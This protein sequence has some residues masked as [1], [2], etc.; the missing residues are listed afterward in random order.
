MREAHEAEILLVLNEGLL[1]RDEA[2]RL[3]EDA[4]RQGRGPLELLRERGR[5]S[6]DTLA[7]LRRSVHEPAAPALL[8]PDGDATRPPPAPAPGPAIAPLARLGGSSL[9]SDQAAV[10]PNKPSS[11]V[12]PG[13][14]GFPLPGWERYRPVRF[15][16]QGGMGRVFLAYDERLHREVA[17]KFVRQDEPELT[18]RFLDEARL[19]ARVNHERVCKVYEVGQEQGRTYIAMQYVDGEPLGH[20]GPTLSAEQKALL[21]RDAALGVHEAHRAGL[22]HRDLKPSNIMV[23]RAG[24]GTLK[25][26]VMDFG[27]ARE[28]NQELTA[29]GT[30]LGTPHYMSP[31]QARGEVGRLDRRADV[32]S[33]GATLYFLLTGRPPIPGDNALEVLSHIPTHEPHPPR[34]VDPDIPEDLEAIALKCLEKDRSARYDSARALADDLERFLSGEPVRARTG[35]GYRLRKRLRKHRALVTVF[36]VALVLVS[37]TALWAGLARRDAALR[38]QLA[39]RFTERVER[40]ESLAR[41]SGLSPLHDTRKDRKALRES[42]AALEAE[43]AAGGERALGPGHYA[44]G[45]G[46]LAL[47][48]YERARAALEKAWEH[49]ERE[50]RVAYALAV[51]MGRL[52]QEGLSD[53]RRTNQDRAQR[54]ARRREVE[55]RFRDPALAYLQQSTGAEV[56]SPAYV[57][58][59]L[60]FY[61][62]RYEDALARLEALDESL[63]WFYEGSWLRGDI[64]VDRAYA[65]WS[66]GDQPGRL[67]DLEAARKAYTAAAAIGESVPA[68]HQA[69]ARLE[70]MAL[71]MELYGRGADVLPH[72]TRAQEAV[73]RAL[74]AAP[75]HVPSRV[76]QAQL[77]RRLAEYRLT[78][79]GD[80]EEPLAKALELAQGVLSLAPESAAVLTELG[81]VY[82]QR[83]R[84]RQGRAEDPRED[85]RKAVELFERVEPKDRGYDFLLSLGLVFT[86]WADHEDK[87]GADASSSRSRAIQAYQDA[88]AL[89]ENGMAAWSNLGTAYFARA[90][91]PQA[92][93]TEGDLRKARE[94]LAKARALNPKYVVPYYYA[95]KVAELLAR[96]EI[97]RGE[98]G[99]PEL[100]EAAEHYR[101]GL[102]VNPKFLALLNGM[103]EV[104]AAHA[105]EGWE[106]G[107]DPFPLLGEAVASFEKMLALDS[108]QPAALNNAGEMHAR[109]AGY[110]RERGEDP[111]LATRQSAELFRRAAEVLT[112]SATPLANLALVHNNLSLFELEHG[113]DPSASLTRAAEAAKGALARSPEGAEAWLAH[114][115]AQGLKARWKARQGQARAEDFE[116]AHQSYEKALALGPKEQKS[117]L[118]FGH[119]CRA[120][121]E[122]LRETNQAPGPA[123]KRAEELSGELLS[124]RPGWA[125]A[126]V[127]RATVLASMAETART[128]ERPGLWRQALD[129]LT[130]A[131]A[132]NPHL[133]AVWRPRLAL[134]QRRATDS[135]D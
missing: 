94:A 47:E 110:Q 89:D 104:K 81:S 72:F 113:R 40:I 68:I 108:K 77:Y 119:F 41:Y 43:I 36:A 42:M 103:G 60:A 127:L 75:D 65:R 101:Q 121:A 70:S 91:S 14:E 39:R 105:Q 9:S 114:A 124:T 64:L 11:D 129:E 35:R 12:A 50:P 21:L 17:L 25:P 106:H 3:R 48:E 58:A 45:R 19:Q 69:L 28:W 55:A 27:L 67:A 26:Y 6:P 59:L 63:P 2:E 32:Y 135:R 20:L 134:W 22:I 33:L 13:D 117:R 74:T 93:D 66:Q 51:V 102:D 37:S 86:A 125:Q 5:I 120:W 95:G 111:T 115:E 8:S 122:W 57:A 99:R 112:A 78:H 126:R 24:D 79:G 31:E 15:L 7:L 132:S 56:P 98:D 131:L 52:Y 71:A 107:G 76:M 133:E 123:L 80:V 130:K 97:E 87:V 44:L 116:A 100:R 62:N 10:T 29:T 109:K 82:W 1:S 30:V 54:E 18:R 46:Y 128:E 4:A 85:L 49:G 84:Y 34:A 92:T 90:S 61:E 96:R 83:G 118:S 38:E 53:V 73:S 23:E 16:G 88:L